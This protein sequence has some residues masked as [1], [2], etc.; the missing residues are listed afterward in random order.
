[1]EVVNTKGISP[2]NEQTYFL[3]ESEMFLLM[4]YDKRTHHVGHVGFTQDSE[5][6]PLHKR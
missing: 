4:S 1:M 5:V 2:L 6:P 3:I